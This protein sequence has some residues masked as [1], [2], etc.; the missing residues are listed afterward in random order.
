MPGGCVEVTWRTIRAAEGRRLVLRWAERDGP[1]VEGTP[2]AGF[3]HELSK[4]V[5]DYELEGQAFIEF[6][7]EGLR[8]MLEMPMPETVEIA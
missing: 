7:R 3:G 5:V 1:P 8:C 6:R 4:R 2:I